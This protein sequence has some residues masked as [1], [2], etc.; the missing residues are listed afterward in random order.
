MDLALSTITLGHSGVDNL[1]HHGRD[2]QACAITLDVRNDG[3]SRHIQREV[4][5]D[6]DLLAVGRN[7]HV[8]VHG[9]CLF[10]IV[11]VKPGQDQSLSQPTVN[12]LTL[13]AV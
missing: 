7:I 3:V 12:V 2:V 11:V 1:E 8:L 9:L 4:G 13:T 10:R 6:R 5:V